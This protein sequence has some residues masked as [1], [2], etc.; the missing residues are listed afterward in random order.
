MPSSETTHECK[1]ELCNWT[2]WL[3]GSYPGS[4]RNSGDFD[5]FV[6]LR[7][8]GYKF[9]EKPRNVECRAQFFPNTPLE[10]L[11]QN[12]TCS[13]EEGLICLNKNQLPPMCY[14]YEI[15]IECCTV[16]NNCSTAS[17]TTHPTSH[18]V[19]TKTE[20]NWTTHV[21]SSPTKD[22][23]SHSAT[24]DTKTWT[25]G[26]SHT[27]TQPVTTHCQLQCNWTKW[28]DTD[29]PVPGPHGGDLETYSNIERSGERLCHREEITQLQCRAKNY[30][31]REMKD[32]GQV[33][34]CDPSV[35][36]VCNNRDQGGDSGMCLNY[37][38]RLLCCHIPEDCPR[39]DQTS[40]VTLSHKPSSAV[41]SPSSVSPSLLTSHRV[42]STT[43][44]FCSVSGQ[45]YPLGK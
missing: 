30:P 6:N 7:S 13:R 25:S 43:P 11:G 23:S 40:P 12:V 17:V 42:H 24:I 44:C 31:E 16:V 29:F 2:N 26:S 28:F 27:S 3:D 34:Q 35:G 15:R 9:C 1:Q 33:V 36:L 39:T 8:K 22:T 18:G 21:Y 38:V 4:G 5:T 32:L 20:T 41:V 14:N 45:L 10:E 37:E 19:S